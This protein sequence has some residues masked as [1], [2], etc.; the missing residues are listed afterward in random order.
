[1]KHPLY[2]AALA[3]LLSICTAQFSAGQEW[4]RFRGPNGEGQSDADTIPLKW[5]SNDY[6]WR[7]KLPGIGHSSPVVQG[8]R[9]FVTS[10]VEADA[11][12][13]IRCLRTSDGGLIW[14]REFAS[15]THPKNQNNNYAVSTPAL[16]A[17]RVYLTWATPQEYTVVA[18]TQDKGADVWRRNLGPFESEHGFGS[19][20]TLFDGAVIVPNDQLGP[21]SVIALDSAT[22]ETR[23]K[24]DRQSVKAAFSTPCI[25]RPD[26][27]SPQLILTS[28]AHGITSL[29][30]KTGKLNW[31]LPIFKERVVGSPAVASGLIFASAGTGGGGRQMVAVRPG[32]PEKGTEAKVAYEIVGSL[33]YVPTS[34]ASGDLI[35]LWNDQG[36]VTCMDAPTGKIHWRERVEGKYF[37]SPIRVGNRIYCISRE[38]DMVVVAASKAFELLARVGLEEPSNATPVVDG[39]V[40]Y[41][42]TLTHLMAIGGK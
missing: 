8:E 9:I 31:E 12:R 10:A 34:V 13:I 27:G 16:D 26:G 15:T 3:V 11:T 20:P 24:T 30:P 38:G 29:D 32:I 41:L 21:S 36:I 18:L 42:R 14:K 28:T 19:S 6:K 5:T 35:F 22:G 23:W 17:S 2:P 1:M 37:G 4:T 25:Y 33:P 40:M 7:V 39:G